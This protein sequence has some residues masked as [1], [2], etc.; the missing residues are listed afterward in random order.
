[1]YLGTEAKRIRNKSHSRGGGISQRHGFSFSNG[2][3]ENLDL[4][5]HW[6]LFRP[7]RHAATALQSF[8]PHSSTA[9]RKRL[10]S[11]LVQLLRM[12]LAF[13]LRWYL[14][15]HS[16]GVLFVPNCLEIS[17]QLQKLCCCAMLSSFLSS[18]FCHGRL[19]MR[20]SS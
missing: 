6:L 20:G 1:M 15:K 7:S 14:I 13:K 8:S 4:M 5:R 19:L 2:H 12:M 11:S 10:S 16:A 17:S 18:T 3:G 9:A